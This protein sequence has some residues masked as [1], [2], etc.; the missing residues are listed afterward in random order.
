MQSVEL[1]TESACLDCRP[2]A[3]A[4]YVD[5][6]VCRYH[7]APTVSSAMFLIQVDWGTLVLQLDSSA[8]REDWNLLAIT[9]TLSF[10]S[11]RTLQLK[12]KCQSDQQVW[13]NS[14]W[15][16]GA[17]TLFA[18]RSGPVPLSDIK[19]NWILAVV[20][21]IIYWKWIRVP[22][23]W[24]KEKIIVLLSSIFFFSYTQFFLL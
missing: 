2:V 4:L 16:I 12:Y 5:I 9:I 14:I 8:E 7:H 17:F 6:I 20:I 1:H 10:R 22:S 24:L 23:N 13:A 15:L 3:A 19:L 18:G 21:S 11:D